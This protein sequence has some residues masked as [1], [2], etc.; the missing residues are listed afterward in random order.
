[1]I[2]LTCAVKKELSFWTPRDGVEILVTGVGVVEAACAVTHKL[3][4]QRFKLVISA[5]IAG[6]FDGAAK[7]GNGVVVSSERLE[8]DREDG[9]PLALP[10]GDRIV[11][12]VGTCD[13]LLAAKLGTAGFPSVSG[14]TVSRVTVAEATALRLARTGAQVE[15]MEGFAVMR[16]AE[17]A[18]V[19]AVEVRGISNRAGDVARAGWDFA[20]G[21]AGLQRVLAALFIILDAGHQHA[22][23]P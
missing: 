1:M 14:I 3:A 21:L 9:T 15:T 5:G 19:H 20:A 11:D 17:L 22:E 4:Q 12:T 10:D 7:V 2:L 18:G 16:A 13:A 23:H 6:T 8:L